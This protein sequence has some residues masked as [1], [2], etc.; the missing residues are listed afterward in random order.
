ML[1]R[2]LVDPVNQLIMHLWKHLIQDLD[3]S[4]KMNIGFYH[5]RTQKRKLEHGEQITIQIDHIVT[6]LQITK[7]IYERFI[8]LICIY[9]ILLIKF[10]FSLDYKLDTLQSNSFQFNELTL[11][12]DWSLTIR[13]IIAMKYVESHQY[14]P[15]IGYRNKG[16]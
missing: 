15:Y 1:D 11:V 3:K 10:S 16:Y 13:I 6:W 5:W 2:I 14:G 4:A 12:W 9:Q 7:R 8:I